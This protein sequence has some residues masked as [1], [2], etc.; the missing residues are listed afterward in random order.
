MGKNIYLLFI[1][2]LLSIVFSVSGCGDKE[3]EPAPEADFTAS[4]V[5][6]EA[7]LSVQFTDISIGTVTAWSWDFNDDGI[8][9]SNIQ[10]PQHLFQTPGTYT[11]RF[12][13]TG[14]GGE[15]EII[16]ENLISANVP[17]P[18]QADFM[19]TPTSG[20]VPLTIYFTNESEGNINSWEWDFDNDSS[21]DSYLQNPTH[22][23]NTGGYYTVTLSVSGLG[24][25][26]SKTK[27]Q[28]ILAANEVLYV[29]CRATSSGNGSSWATAFTT[30]Q[31]G[32][33]AA[34]N[35]DLVLVADGTYSGTDN[36]N[37]DFTGKAI[38]LR[39]AGGAE[40][41]II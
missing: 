32:L 38:R 30:I 26:D 24:G 15:D 7:P 37:L 31:E 12:K 16:K 22:T 35:Y 28:Y 11:I 13:A 34:N 27:T 4:P 5:I 14:A 25:S 41:C 6:G 19:A 8:E 18:P 39:S 20:E 3:K 29:D 1:G 21:I 17:P 36:T 33:T 40:N 23:Y 10:N 2:I 9:D